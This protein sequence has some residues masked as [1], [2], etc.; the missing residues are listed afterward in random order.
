MWF[1]Y[2]GEYGLVEIKTSEQTRFH[3]QNIQPSQISG[4]IRCLAAG[5]HSIFL[6]CKIPEWQWHYVDG[7]TILDLRKNGYKS[8]S[9]DDMAKIKLKAE[10]ILP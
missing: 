7:Q 5:G 9:W 1:L 6:I 2:K 4:A 3:F 10:E 8:M